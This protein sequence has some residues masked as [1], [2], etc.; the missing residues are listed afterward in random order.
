MK[1]SENPLQG[2]GKNKNYADADSLFSRNSGIR[3]ILQ[4]H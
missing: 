2:L 3:T 4:I 1:N